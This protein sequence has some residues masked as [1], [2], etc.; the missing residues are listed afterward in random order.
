[1]KAW[2]EKGANIS[3]RGREKL[4]QLK[5]GDVQRILIIRHAALGDMLQTRPFLIECRRFFPKA[6]ITLALI[7]NYQLGAPHDLVDEVV[8]IPGRDQPHVSFWMLLRIYFR[9]PRF[10][11]LFDMACT[12]RSIVQT[13]FTRAKFKLGFPYRTKYFI[14]DAE[15]FRSEFN[16]EAEVLVHFLNLLGHRA[17]YPVQFQL[18]KKNI[19][20]LERERIFS[21]FL[22]S[23]NVHRN[24]P[25]EQFI[26][27]IAA[28]S[29]QYPHY[30]HVMLQG[31]GEHEKFDSAF[32][33]LKT[34]NC[35]NVFLKTSGS[36]EELQ[37][38][39]SNVRYMVSNDTG[40]RH[41]AMALN[42]PGMGIF[43]ITIPYRN[44][45]PHDPYQKCIFDA[46]SGWPSANE[47]IKNISEHGRSIG[48]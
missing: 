28:L 41:L 17:N 13:I 24:Y 8:V 44:W 6:H 40:V 25:E 42:T 19:P 20:L 38:Y 48:I 18:T 1:M 30:Q 39:L 43:S 21:Y 33:K 12:S 26:E 2:A 14:F 4:A 47:V 37:T 45:N 9:M 3:K 23:S 34:Q 11:L 27:V 29:R 5:R 36:L 35:N 32:A 7:S 16:Y 15:I 46:E 22:S 10:D 31:S